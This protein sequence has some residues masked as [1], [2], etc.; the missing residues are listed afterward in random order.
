MILPL[1]A[2]VVVPIPLISIFGTQYFLI[3]LYS[4]INQ[5]YCIGI[6]HKGFTVFKVG[7]KVKYL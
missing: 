7:A 3:F 6:T 5:Q 1:A 2:T 4:S